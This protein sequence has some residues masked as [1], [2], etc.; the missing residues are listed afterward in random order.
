MLPG[1]INRGRE[2]G[3]GWDCTVVSSYISKDVTV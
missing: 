2:G 1:M 3:G